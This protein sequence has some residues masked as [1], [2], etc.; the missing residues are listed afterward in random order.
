VCFLT[1]VRF[2]NTPLRKNTTG[3]TK[4]PA[5]EGGFSF[6]TPAGD[7]VWWD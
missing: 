3:Q 6:E 4:P 7:S 5:G 1:K 2:I